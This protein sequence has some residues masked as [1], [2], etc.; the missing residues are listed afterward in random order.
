MLEHHPWSWIPARVQ[1]RV[2]LAALALTALVMAALQ[3]LGKP[4]IT[5]AAPSG[6]VSYELAGTLPAAQAI[7]GSWNTRAQLFAGVNLGL[8][9]LFMPAYATCI[10]LGCVLAARRFAVEST[11][12]RVG[13]AL[14]WGL[15]LAALLD[16]LENVAL[17]RLLLATQPGAV[18]PAVARLAALIKFAL[19]VLGI[20]YA[21]LGGLLARARGAKPG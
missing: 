18:W 10:G 7:L 17:L 19:V 9:Y 11:A 15:A 4:L 20:G 21:L 12:R 16:V 8:D 2:F 13:L 14:A 6:I 5:V 1:L 3:L